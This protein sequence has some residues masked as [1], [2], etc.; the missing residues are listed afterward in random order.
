MLKHIRVHLVTFKAH[1]P[2]LNSMSVRKV[3]NNDVTRTVHPSSYCIHKHRGC[4]IT[5]VFV[6]GIVSY[7]EG[8]NFLQQNKDLPKRAIKKMAAVN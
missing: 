4:L 1:P 6:S 3:Q 8:R 2:S 7:T 5:Y